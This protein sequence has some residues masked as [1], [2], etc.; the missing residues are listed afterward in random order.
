MNRSAD[1]FY[2][3]DLRDALPRLI[4]LLKGKDAP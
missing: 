1:Y 4:E 2:V 3:G